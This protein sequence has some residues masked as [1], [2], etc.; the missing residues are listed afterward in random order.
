MEIEKFGVF[1]WNQK[2]LG[3]IREEATLTDT[4]RKELKVKKA[5]LLVLERN[6]SEISPILCVIFFNKTPNSD[7][8]F[9]RIMYLSKKS[10]LCE[11]YDKISDFL[12]VFIEEN[13][14]KLLNNLNFINKLFINKQIFPFKL[15][16]LSKESTAFSN[17]IS[18]EIPLNSCETIEDF[19]MIS[20]HKKI[21]NSF[22]IE[23]IWLGEALKS[24]EVMNTTKNSQEIGEIREENEKNIYDCLELFSREE[25]LEETNEWFCDKC[26]KFQMALKKIE[27]YKAPKIVIFQI[28]RFKSNKSLNKC[29]IN[30]KID[31]PINDLN[32]AKFVINHE[33]PEKSPFFSEN[34]CFLK[35]KIEKNALNSRNFYGKSFG[36][37]EKFVMI[38]AKILEENDDIPFE[39]EEIITISTENTINKE[40]IVMK[41]ERNSPFCLEN[42][43]LFYELFGVIEHKGNLGYGHYIAKC[44]NFYGE[45]WHK[46]DDE[47]VCEENEADIVNNNAYILFYK[48]KTN[49]Y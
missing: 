9:P 28:K 16:I 40:K 32:L 14:E 18:C 26:K 45:K 4:L 12:A 13:R 35:E 10:T 8:F 44:K 37:T 41:S 36:K 47:E 21:E 19:F 1:S 25:R 11:L 49:K 20:F 39:E 6:L 24:F 29:K 2:E 30:D 34:S 33:L 31:F 38:P 15:N 23:V 17:E 42:P 3:E 43:G 5:I 7:G 46:F 22:E 48:R 27:I